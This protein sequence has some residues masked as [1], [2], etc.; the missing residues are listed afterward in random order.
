MLSLQQIVDAKFRMAKL[1]GGY[2]PEDVDEFADAVRETVESLTKTVQKQQ[3]DINALNQENRQLQKKMEILAQKVEE[4]RS[5]EDGIKTALISAQKLGDASI[6]EARH[7]SEIIV[8]DA[9]MKADQIVGAAGEEAK[10]Y[11]Q[12]LVDLKQA[13]S[14]FRSQ[15]LDMYKQ[16]LTLITTL[17]TYTKPVEEP[18]ETFTEEEELTTDEFDVEPSLFEE[19][20]PE[21]SAADMAEISEGI[22]FSPADPF[23]NI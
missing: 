17:P 4:Y 21:E 6:R 9:Q 23:G 18:E 7:K 14:D 20:I 11:E 12:E 16:H 2:K 1:P 15:I 13:V 22:S 3:E 10:T 19:E 5:E 8:K